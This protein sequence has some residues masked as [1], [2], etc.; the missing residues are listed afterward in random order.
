MRVDRDALEAVA[1]EEHLAGASGDPHEG[2]AG[3]DEE[4]GHR[5]TSSSG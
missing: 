3:R 5:G 4:V 2:G 1:L